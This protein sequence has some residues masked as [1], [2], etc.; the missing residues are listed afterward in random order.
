MLFVDTFNRW[1]EPENA[2]AALAVLQAA[3]YR[4]HLPE[5]EVERR[6]LCCGRTFL[7]A[8]LVDA[9]RAELRRTL[10]ALAPHLARGLPVVGL[11]PSCLFTFRDELKAILP[12]AEAERLAANALMFEEFLDREANA[13]RLDLPLRPI[14]H[15]SAL[16][17]G[18]CHQ[19]AFDAV[20]ASRSVLGLIPDLAVEVVPSSCCG[21][22]GAFGYEADHYDVSMAMAELSLLPAVRAAGDDVVVVADGTSCRQQ[23]RHGAG[24]DAV[25]VARLMQRALA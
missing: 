10:A 12:G 11:E 21:M 19:K 7:A 3:G 24:R 2:S 9:A 6:P 5:A 15:G 25:H 13:G 4:V 18:H 23:I 14:D 1:F 22:A 17:H 20:D 16:L 8:G